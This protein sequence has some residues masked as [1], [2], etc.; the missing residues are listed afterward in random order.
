MAATR[1]LGLRPAGAAR[2]RPAAEEG[3]VAYPSFA[4]LAIVAIVL[5][6]CSGSRCT[7]ATTTSSPSTTAPD[8][9][10]SVTPVA[11]CPPRGCS[12]NIGHVEVG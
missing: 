9:I 12:R 1:P 4:M 7:A 5:A 10:P 6:A 11:A 2:R 3:D 8:S